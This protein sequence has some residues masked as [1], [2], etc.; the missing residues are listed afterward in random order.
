LLLVMDENTE[1]IAAMNTHAKAQYA[2]ETGKKPPKNHTSHAVDA[3]W[4]IARLGREAG[5]YAVYAHQRPDVTY[6]PGE[7]RDNLLSRYAAGALNGDGAEMM[8]DS[9]AI[10]QR[11]TISE[12]N[13][14]TGELHHR[15]VDGRATVQLGN[16]PEPLQGYWTPKIWDEQE[17]PEGSADATN[18]APL[19]PAAQH[20]WHNADPGLLPGVLQI[21]DGDGT[22]LGATGGTPAH[23]LYATGQASIDSGLDASTDDIEDEP[24]SDEPDDT[25]TGDS[26]AVD[27]T[28]T[29]E[30]PLDRADGP[31]VA[32]V[33]PLTPHTTQPDNAPS[34]DPPADAA[35]QNQPAETAPTTGDLL[36]RAAEV[37]ITTQNA[38]A[39][40]LAREL[41]TR[42]A[43]T[44]ELLTALQE[45]GI[46]GPPAPGKPRAVH[47]TAEALHGARQ[48]LTGHA[49]HT[50]GSETP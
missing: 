10:E 40:A 30:E 12:A 28:K 20:A 29:P 27:L 37:V 48:Q 8:F 42:Q 33:I 34:T 24:A 17:C 9:Q 23:T 6:I 26:P 7:A 49:E 47:F 5:T 18:M 14:D 35:Q 16:G 45:A 21:R 32:Q 43:T 44:A 31:A 19:Q 41:H 2:E 22:I 36:T 39:A 38:S 15:P 11:V 4:E 1:A 13:P 46:V 50:E 25:M 3:L